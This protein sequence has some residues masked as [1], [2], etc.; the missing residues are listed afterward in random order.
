MLVGYWP[1]LHQ[2]GRPWSSARRPAWRCPHRRRVLGGP[3]PGSPEGS[4]RR[5]RRTLVLPEGMP[6][7]WSRAAAVG[8]PPAP[9]LSRVSV[10]G[11]RGGQSAARHLPKPAETQMTT[12]SP[13]L[14]RLLSAAMHRE[15]PPQTQEEVGAPRVHVRRGGRVSFTAP[16]GQKGPLRPR[17]RLDVSWELRVDDDVE[18]GSR[19]DVSVGLFRVGAPTKD[20]AIVAKQGKGT[21]EETGLARGAVAF[22]APRAAGAFVFRLLDPEPPGQQQKPKSERPKA[23]SLRYPKLMWLSDPDI[24]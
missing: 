2:N 15:E 5:P 20:A 13:R 3:P 6:P 18:V 7:S 22:F 9:W 11:R 17:A 23:S 8:G 10:G 21:V 16:D 4:A 12:T 24:Y 19:R 14:Y 1:C